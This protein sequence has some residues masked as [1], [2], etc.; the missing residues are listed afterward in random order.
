MPSK[1]TARCPGDASKT[2]GGEYFWETFQG[3]KIAAPKGGCYTLAATRSLP[4]FGNS[5]TYS[6]TSTKMTRTVCSEACQERGS[7]WAGVQNGNK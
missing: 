3:P 1:C 6:F 2:C 4:D 5:A 7:A